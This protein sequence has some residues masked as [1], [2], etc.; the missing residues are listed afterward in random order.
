MSK[1]SA[2]L[3]PPSE[4]SINLVMQAAYNAPQANCQTAQQTLVALDELGKFFRALLQIKSQDT[5]AVN[6]P[7]ALASAEGSSK[8]QA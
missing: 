7:Q 5:G 4:N 2:A 1:K 8:S 3:A 6:S